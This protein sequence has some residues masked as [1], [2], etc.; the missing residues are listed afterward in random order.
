MLRS[1]VVVAGLAGLAV[2]AAT[3]TPAPADAASAC[4]RH[5]DVAK[6]LAQDFAERPVAFGLQSDGTLM[7][8]FA[9][10]KG[11]TWTVVL[12]DASGRSCVVAEGV[13]WESLPP[14]AN[15]PLV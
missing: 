10:S 2:A 8:V 12:T 3:F 11:A 4:H 1:L 5:G 6:A 9:S 7:Q 13:R 15:G 14:P